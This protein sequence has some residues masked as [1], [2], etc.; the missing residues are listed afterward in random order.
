VRK[1]LLI[2]RTSDAAELAPLTAL[3]NLP[4]SA[5]VVTPN[6]A[7]H[8]T[9]AAAGARWAGS[10]GVGGRDG[11][12]ASVLVIGVAQH[13]L[14]IPLALKRPTTLVQSPASRRC[15]S[16][17]WVGMVGG[18]SMCTP[19][20]DTGASHNHPGPPQK[21]PTLPPFHGGYPRG[22]KCQWKLAQ[23]AEWECS[24]PITRLI[25]TF[26]LP[27]RTKNAVTNHAQRVAR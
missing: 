2:R 24:L 11:L 12:S 23:D 15:Q 17:A 3:S 14:F 5:V 25:P 22:V 27:R 19:P 13:G 26:Q 6:R 1:L 10:S 9:A 18:V 8:H 21:T 20:R 4:L 16:A 7:R